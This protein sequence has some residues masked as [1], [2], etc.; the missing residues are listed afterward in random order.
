MS[1]HPAS[2][3][4][5][6]ASGSPSLHSGHCWPQ[7]SNAQHGSFMLVQVDVHSDDPEDEQVSSHL[8]LRSLRANKE[9]SGC[10][11]QTPRS[12]RDECMYH[13]YTG[14]CDGIHTFSRCKHGVVLCNGTAVSA[15][16]K[17]TR[18]GDA[19]TGTSLTA[20]HVEQDEQTH[21]LSGFT[22]VGE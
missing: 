19:A 13:R 9:S 16:M 12:C 5:S 14:F 1:L 7:Q 4:Q 11:L 2:P 20:V 15:A 21:K 6:R 22:I 3:D 17:T 8:G 18:A 10:L